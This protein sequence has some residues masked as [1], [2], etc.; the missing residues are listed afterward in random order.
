MGKE[1]IDID[2][3]KEYR[4]ICRGNDGANLHCTNSVGSYFCECWQ[5]YTTN[6]TDC[7]DIDECAN[8]G[9][10]PEKATCQNVEASYSCHCTLGFSGD[11]C[12]DTDE[13]SIGTNSCDES[14]DCFNNYGSYACSCKEGYHGDGKNCD[15]GL[16]DD[17]SCPVNQ[18]CVRPTSFECECKAGF[19]TTLSGCDDFDECL[20]GHNCHEHAE[21]SNLDGSFTCTCTDG[22]EGNG[23]TCLKKCPEGFERNDDQLC[24]DTDE[25]SIDSD[26]CHENAICSNTEGSYKCNCTNGF[27]GSGESCFPGS[28]PDFIC[29]LNQKCVSPTTTECECIEGFA[30]HNFSECTDINECEATPCD[31]NASCINVQGNF[32]CSC[33]SGFVGDGFFCDLNECATDDHNCHQNATC[34]NTNGSFTC[35]CNTHFVGDGTV[36]FESFILV[37]NILHLTPNPA[38]LINMFG[39]QEELACFDYGEI[40]TTFACS[41]SWQNKLHIFGGGLQTNYRQIVRLDGHKLT[42]IGSLD[43]DHNK[44]ACSVM[45]DEIY[46]CFSFNDEE[47]F[48]DSNQCRKSTDPL[49]TFTSVAYTKYDHLRARI[50]NSNSEFIQEAS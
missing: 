10:C 29:P 33:F 13:C 15:E 6:G 46:L 36:C 41:I 26:V 18:K 14:A 19:N 37:I 11:L 28:C 38:I 23:V 3:C 31:V 30:F 35:S 4:D 8:H 17:R 40:S 12:T 2:E 20:S 32:T 50:S 5:G 34:S 22:Y 47:T 25:C 21:C 44:G 9:I 7:F 48:P 27:Y 1:C 42:N 16:C 43:F 45:A 24:Q 39:E 49:Q